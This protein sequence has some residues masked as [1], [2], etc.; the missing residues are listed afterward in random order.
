MWGQQLPPCS[1]TQNGIPAYCLLP[2]QPCPFH[3]SQQDVVVFLWEKP[4]NTLQHG[5]THGHLLTVWLLDLVPHWMSCAHSQMHL[6]VSLVLGP[7]VSKVSKVSVS[8]IN[9]DLCDL[10]VLLTAEKCNYYYNNNN[11]E[12]TNYRKKKTAVTML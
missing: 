11:Q 3:G 6:L 1:V 10:M 9:C 2:Y 5:V 4:G 7:V 8:Y 12:D